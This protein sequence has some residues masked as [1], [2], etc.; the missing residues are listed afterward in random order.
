VLHQSLETARDLKDQLVE[1]SA[2]AKLAGLE[3]IR[4]D[5]RQALNYS[6]QAFRLSSPEID[7]AM[8]NELRYDTSI[9]YF[10][11]GDYQRSSDELQKVLSFMRDHKIASGEGTALGSLAQLQLR[12][13]QPREALTTAARS[14]TLLRRS[15]EE[16]ALQANVLYTQA[17]ANALVCCQSRMRPPAPNFFQARAMSIWR[18]SICWRRSARLMKLSRWLSL[19]TAVRFST[20][21][22]NR[23]PTCTRLC[24]VNS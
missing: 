19:I 5:Y 17:R 9:A 6:D 8:K 10:G 13:G 15:G 22:P 7:A 24:R 21:W 1:F 16:P 2:L 4:A 11:L 3:L 23:A 12:L 18:R 14:L 20:R